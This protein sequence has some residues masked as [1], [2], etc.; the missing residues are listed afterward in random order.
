MTLSWCHELNPAVTVLLVIPV[1]KIANPVS[2]CPS[3]QTAST[4]IPAYISLSRTNSPMGSA[5]AR[6]SPINLFLMMFFSAPPPFFS[7][8]PTGA[9]A[10]FYS[11]TCT[12]LVPA[13]CSLPRGPYRR[14]K[15]PADHYF[16]RENPIIPGIY[17]YLCASS[18]LTPA[19][20][21]LRPR[22]CRHPT[23]ETRPP[24]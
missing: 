17:V 1:N 12:Q 19:A 15:L 18:R 2:R 10:P 16:R 3:S 8:S 14:L 23:P 9:V 4:E 22:A 5:G 24:H 7:S 6:V 11:R 13:L 21:S 20:L